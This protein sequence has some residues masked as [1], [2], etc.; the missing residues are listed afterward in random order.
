MALKFRD[1]ALFIGVIS[2]L[3]AITVNL[4]NLK[5][6][7][8]IYPI[9]DATTLFYLFIIL[10]TALVVTYI[11]AWKRRQKPFFFSFSPGRSRPFSARYRNPIIGY[12]FGVKWR[13]YEPEPMEK[14]PWADGPYCPKC[15]RDLE[16][17]VKGR[18]RKRQYWNC[19][20]CNQDYERPK[21]N[22]KNQVEKNFA[23]EL[24]RQGRLH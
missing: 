3:L 16:E 5:I 1:I 2:Y 24:R 21:G 7:D 9:I 11:I 6:L 12:D 15:D 10:G 20:L 19:P 18:L 4:Q 22:V 23:A 8:W 17:V 13:L 14:Q